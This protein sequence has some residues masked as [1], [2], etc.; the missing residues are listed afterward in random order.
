MHSVSPPGSRTRSDCVCEPRRYYGSLAAPGSECM[1][2]PFAQQCETDNCSC[3]Q[4]WRPVYDGQGIMR[5]VAEC[6][7]GEYARVDPITFKKLECVPCPLHTYSSSRQTVEVV[8]RSAQQQC[9]PC[10]LNLET[11]EVGR[12]SVLDCLCRRG[13]MNASSCGLCGAGS[14]LDA[15]MDVCRPCPAG[16]TSPAGSVGVLSCTCPSGSRL[17][18]TSVCEPCP[19][20]TYSSSAGMSCTPCPSPMVTAG[21]GSKSIAEC[22][23]PVD[24]GYYQHAGRCI[25]LK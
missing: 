12:T 18:S 16:S 13:V 24:G 15:L 25:S 7:L 6:A 3:A 19:R 14:Y 21:E 10:P 5:C 17:K 8:G 20:N 4:G 11:M 23:C 22:V 2:R 1:P 9:T